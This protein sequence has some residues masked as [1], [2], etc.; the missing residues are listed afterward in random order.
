MVPAPEA[1]VSPLPE[2][3]VDESFVLFVGRLEKRKGIL[4]LF[5]AIPEV[6]ERHPKAKF[7]V[8]GSDNSRE[9]G[10]FADHGMDYPTYFRKNH[11]HATNSVEFTGFVDDARLE[12]LYRT[13]DVFV[14]PS[15]YESFGLIFLEA[16]NWARP[17]IGCAAGG[18]EEIVIEGETGLL[19]PPSDAERLADAIIEL[20][21]SSVRRR[22]MGLAGRRR[23]VEMYS[24][25]AMARG[26]ERLY[27]VLVEGADGHAASRAGARAELF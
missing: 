20:L 2:H 7:I 15:L 27:R 4:E 26:F 3:E 5:D 9:D 25:I 1:L 23:L 8:A 19:V 16:M 13:C 24:H 21:S 18:P 14:A 11:G 22:E 10:F 12:E 6:L 17:V